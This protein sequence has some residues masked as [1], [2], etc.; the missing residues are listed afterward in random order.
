MKR[1]FLTV[2][3]AGGLC[4]ARP[5][6]PVRVNR[7]IP[8]VRLMTRRPSQDLINGRLGSL[9]NDV[10]QRHVGCGLKVRQAV[11]L[12]VQWTKLRSLASAQDGGSPC[13]FRRSDRMR[14]SPSH[15]PA[16][17]L[18]PQNGVLAAGMG[19]RTAHALQL[20][21]DRAPKPGAGS[22]TCAASMAERRALRK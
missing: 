22:P 13:Q 20:A 14:F 6:A 7:N 8:P 1:A 9:T 17:G 4:F 5:A 16:G 19:S 3:F 12:G 21:M 15:D 18:D 2:L 10:Q 11:Q